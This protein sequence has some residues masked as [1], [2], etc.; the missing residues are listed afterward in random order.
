MLTTKARALSQSPLPADLQAFELMASPPDSG[1]Y[2]TQNP[3]GLWQ[4]CQAGQKPLL[5]D[6]SSA[7]YRHRGGTEYLPKA[8][9]GMSGASILDA[10]AGWGRDAWLLA[11]RGFHL[12]LCERNPYLYVLLKQGIE[13]AKQLPLTAAVAN[14]MRIIHDDSRQ[15]LAAHGREFDAIYLDPMYPQRQKSAKVK[16]E[17]QILHELLGADAGEQA[18][19]AELLQT[20]L[21][22]GCA[23]IVV[24]RPQTAAA[25]A[26][27]AP[28]HSIEAPNTRYDVYL[29]Q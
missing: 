13:Q 5:I 8:F 12:C 27:L 22:S 19:N 29:S 9:K 14:R 7:H 1:F 23:K 25:L 17:M 26:A 24:K 20:A 15:F 10:T 6:F 18:D 4:L 11:Y 3:Q 2:L 21:H 28:H 16:K